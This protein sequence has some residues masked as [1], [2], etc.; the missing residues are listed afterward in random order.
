M[1]RPT[2]S[3]TVLLRGAAALLALA[4]LA[5]AAVTSRVIGLD[6]DRRQGFP[7][8]RHARLFPV[9]TGCHEGIES[10]DSASFFPSPQMCASCHDGENQERVAWSG[11]EARPSNLRF[12][13]PRHMAGL[14][15]TTLQ[16]QSCHTESGAGRM[17]VR[18]VVVGQ[19]LSC[20][21]HRATS[22]YLDAKC[23]TCHV[24][25]ARTA[26]SAERILTL[27]EPSDHEAQ[28]FLTKGHGEEAH[29]GTARCATC[30]TRERC[31]SCHV[32]AST[33]QAIARMPAAAP[34][35][36]LPTFPVHYPVPPSHT[37]PD[38]LRRHGAKAGVAECSTCHAREDCQTCHWEN[39]PSLVTA[40]PSRAHT[41]AP[42]VMLSRTPPASHAAP[43]WGTE[44][45]TLA[46]ASTASCTTCHTR[47][48][49]ADCHDAAQIAQNRVGGTAGAFDA[50]TTP[51]AAERARFHS[52]DFMARHASEAWGRRLECSNCHQVAVFCR[53]CH[54]QE[55]MGTEG[56]LG[57]AFH[58]AQPL[59]LLRHGQAARQGLESCTS[60]HK[61]RD[62]LQ[63][64]STLGAFK[65]NPHGR[66]FDP[67]RAQKKN[68]VICY[69]CHA[70]DPLAGRTP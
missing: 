26:F 54:Q 30:H 27:P 29:S 7:H 70:T 44:H 32:N 65:V 14:R 17:D 38:W 64:H 41:S 63:C 34:G 43:T 19:C 48:F 49:C 1:R 12:T 22:H 45:G 46:A 25:L 68:P 52:P 35:L 60:C 28:D 62:C 39:A 11:P 18:R 3:R 4:L 10:G 13:H 15:D 67:G 24:P 56:R 9:C 53:D 50:S 36:E 31:A 8:E 51:R 6:L 40:L 66:S 59:W 55:G 16:C 42:G 5:G 47:L 21:Q 69:A 2:L 57:G 20:H 61:Q 37:K 33:N 58:D 23:E